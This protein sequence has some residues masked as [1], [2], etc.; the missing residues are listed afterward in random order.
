MH[1]ADLRKVGLSLDSRTVD[2]LDDRADSLDARVARTATRSEIARR[3]IPLGLTAVEAFDS[4]QDSHRLDRREQEALLR[5]AVGSFELE[6]LSDTDVLV[7]ALADAEGIDP[8][9]LRD[10]ILDLQKSDR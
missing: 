5:Q 7:E 10:A 8:D 6:M 9:A 1:M 2:R 4:R 3:V